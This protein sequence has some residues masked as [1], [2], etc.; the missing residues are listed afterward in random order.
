MVY[1][2]LPEA[3]RRV[4]STSTRTRCRGSPD[5]DAGHAAAWAAEFHRRGGLALRNG[6]VKPVPGERVFE[7]LKTFFR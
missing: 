6:K 4:Q 5:G 7:E 1:T 2:L 3:S